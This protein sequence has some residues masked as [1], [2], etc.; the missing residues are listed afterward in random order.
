MVAIKTVINPRVKYEERACRVCGKTFFVRNNAADRSQRSCSKVCATKS[1]HIRGW[2][3]NNLSV[4]W[5]KNLALR[6]IWHPTTHDIAWAAG[7]Y[8]GEGSLAT[9]KH[10]PNHIQINVGQKERWLTDRL[11]DL[12]GGSVC[13]RQMNG[14][15]FYTWLVS[16]VRA[17]GFLLTIYTF[18]SPRRQDQIQAAMGL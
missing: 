15:P 10:S 8:E 16:G 7:I 11:R 17:R 12:F 6:P 2:K 1:R 5:N 14:Q 13:E 9:A 4:D 3:P 18:M